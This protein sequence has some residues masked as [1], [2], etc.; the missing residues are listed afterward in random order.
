MHDD[1]KRNWLLPIAIA[2]PA[3]SVHW[4][5][6]P[7][8]QGLLLGYTSLPERQIDTVVSR[9]ARALS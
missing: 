4:I 7:Q 5:V 2:A 6:Q 8:R 9:L 1:G 3:L